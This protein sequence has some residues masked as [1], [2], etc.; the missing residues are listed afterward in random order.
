MRGLVLFFPKLQQVIDIR[1]NQPVTRGYFI[2]PTAIAGHSC[3][4]RH[5]FQLVE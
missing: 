2:V 3:A 4:H 1:F 5:F